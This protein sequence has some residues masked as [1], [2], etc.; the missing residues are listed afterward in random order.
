MSTGIL[1]YNKQ[2]YVINKWF[3]DK[4]ISDACLVGLNIKLIFTENLQILIN[5][6]EFNV[7][8]NSHII[9]NYSDELNNLENINLNNVKFAI[10]RTRNY[11]ITH[12]L[13]K[14]DI[15]VFNSYK[16]ASICNNK[17]LTHQE[18]NSIGINS[19]KTS[20]ES[21]ESFSSEK[22]N[23]YIEF[24]YVIKSL[25]GHGGNHV[26]KADDKESMLN[27]INKLNH[28]Y[29]LIQRM[30]PNYGKD[31]RVYVIGNKIFKSVIRTNDDDFKSNYTLGGKCK[32][33]VL[34]NNELNLVKKI[35]DY[36]KF[37]FVGIDFILD[38][39]DNFL[40]NEIED[41]VGCRMLYSNDVDILP[42]YVNYLKNTLII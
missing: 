21:M 7:I 35:L 33:Y 16:V 34:K 12:H 10:N 29:F 1:I 37:D 36:T 6:S 19:I 11:Y 40:F 27:I 18:I 32:L 9:S 20:I 38:E 13:E 17:A 42:T 24:P 41:V 4:I 5:N 3:A 31:I 23:E 30:S 39:N 26:Y 28:D 8:N 15:R 14:M 22:L 25:D 2:D